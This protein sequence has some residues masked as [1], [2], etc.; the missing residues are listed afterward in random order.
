MIGSEETSDFWKTVGREVGRQ[1]KIG[2]GDGDPGER[3]RLME[4][5]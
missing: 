2:Q 3:H 4:V 1:V 5:F